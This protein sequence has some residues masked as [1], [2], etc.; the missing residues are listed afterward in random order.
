MA[1]SVELDKT[2]SPLAG[3]SYGAVRLRVVVLKQKAI[4]ETE[5]SESED[6]PGEDAEE[7]IDNGKTPLDSYLE[8]PRGRGKQCVVFLVHGQRH[9]GL[10]NSFVMRS[11]GFKYLRSRTMIIVDLDHLA[12]EAVAEIVQGSRQ[13]LFRGNAYH[14]ISDRIVA[15][16]K[17][18]PDLRRLEAEAEQKIAELETGDEAVRG[19]LDQL[20]E[21][22]RAAGTRV[23]GGDA[24]A[25]KN[26]GE[27]VAVH[28]DRGKVVAR[29]A[30]DVGVAAAGPVLVTVPETALIRLRPNERRLVLLQTDPDK[31]WPNVERI[32]AG[33][34][35]KVDELSLSVTQGRTKG[36]LSLLFNETA[37]A[38]SEDYPISTTLRVF[39]TVKGYSEPRLLQKQLIVSRPGPPPPPPPPHV[40]QESPNF[41]RVTSR[42]PVNLVPGG[43]SF[44][45]KLRWDGMDSLTGGSPPTWQF[46]ARCLTL[47]T[48]PIITFS[49]P[50]GGKFELLL[51]V[52]HG[53]LP[54]QEIRFEVEAVAASGRKLSTVFRAVVAEPPLKPEA[55]KA[56]GPELGGQRRPPYDLRYVSENEWQALPC[57]GGADWSASDAGCFTEPTA[58]GKPLVLMINKDAQLL[59]GYSA[60]M[61]EKKL[62]EKTIQTRLT[63]YNAHVAFHLWQMYLDQNKKRDQDSNGEEDSNVPNEAQ[64]RAEIN[65]VAETLVRLMQVSH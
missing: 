26:Q 55:R 14:A 54:K 57:W 58:E 63:R 23:G 53:L 12:P 40:L 44:H 3:A 35:P 50:F 5:E 60:E 1:K 10:D 28:E 38:E 6:I 49:R 45:V 31:E 30:P 22:H 32:L 33:T 48:F 43:P 15:T 21:E 61:I 2:F 27:R 29:A 51:D 8:R 19:K 7:S 34:E 37:D 46:R 36:T 65:R 56:S 47:E 62:D 9:E 25:G 41:L 59:K 24:E 16:L 17:G 11:L 13:G 42:Q 39:A 4:D 64:M 52:P 18:D 20:I